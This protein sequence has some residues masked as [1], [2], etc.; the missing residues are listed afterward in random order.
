MT[1]LRAARQ[2]EAD[3]LADVHAATA[4]VAYAHIF[5]GRPF[6]IELTRRR[7]R[8]F[9]GRL[10]VAAEAG[11][12]VGFAAAEGDELRALY[13]A[14]ERWDR[15]LGR[16]LLE[17]A[18]PVRQLWVLEDN[19]RGRRFYERQGWRA[20]GTARMAF[21]VRELRYV[22]DLESGEPGTR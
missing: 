13:V 2:D 1:E 15:G 4:A 19:T 18:G 5:G 17:A 6:P 22:R 10:I 9:A 21:G 3:A 12:I 7:Y 11:R 8:E 14:P 20:D 16:R